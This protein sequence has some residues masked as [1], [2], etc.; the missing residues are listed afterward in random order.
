[1]IYSQDKRKTDYL[2]Y[3]VYSLIVLLFCYG[4]SPLIRFYSSD[5]SVFYCMGKAMMNGETAYTDFF[6][7]KGMWLYF[8]NYLGNLIDQVIPSW[9]MYLL[10]SL[11]GF[12]DLIILDRIIGIFVSNKKAR[13]VTTVLLF[14]F[15]LNY[16]TYMGGNYAETYALTFQLI[17]V[18]FALRYY[19]SD[20][21]EHPP[22]YML[23]HGICSGVCLLLRPNL[24]AIWVPFGLFLI[25]RLTGQH[26]F[27]NI[28]Q[29]FL[30]LICGVILSALPVLLYGV[31]HR[32]LS[33]MLFCML[34]FNTAYLGEGGTLKELLKG[35]FFSGASI[36]FYACIIGQII[37]WKSSLSRQLKSLITVDF[38]FVMLMTFMGMRAFGHYF[39]VLFPFAIP[40]F[41][42]VGK[43]MGDI[44]NK[45]VFGL[46]LAA[47]LCLTLCANMRSVLHFFPIDTEYKSMYSMLKQCDEMIGEDAERDT[48]L[49]TS[50]LMQPYVVLDVCPTV[51]YPYIPAADYEHFPDATDSM[52]EEIMS[53]SHKYIFGHRYED[54]YWNVFSDR[55]T[56][57]RE[58]VNRYIADNYQV[59]CTDD[60]YHYVMFVRK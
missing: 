8:F 14:G 12:V 5:S 3:L 46:V 39:Q 51:K 10:E 35:L 44:K 15:S 56:E 31:V 57:M 1:M 58:N 40:F 42:F 55:L 60:T 21:L 9:G 4:F 13:I 22:I 6:D 18:L 11:F 2:L 37:V 30:T 48:L 24:V 7:H 36:V 23:I 43:K 45:S 20:R 59:L 25:V 19:T 38:A 50:N 54:G 27:R 34:T 29:N 47:T 32:N 52:Y 49:T 28:A 26:R 41:V 17:S 53:G 16:F 33:A